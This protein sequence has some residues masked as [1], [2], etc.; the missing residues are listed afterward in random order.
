M[1]WGNDR[2]KPWDGFINNGVMS[3]NQ[4]GGITAHTVNNYAPTDRHIDES[5]KTDLRQQVSKTTPIRVSVAMGDAE[6]HAFGLEIQAFLL[7]DGFNVDV[8][9][10]AQCVWMSPVKGQ[11]LQQEEDGSIQVI[12]GSR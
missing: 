2:N 9:A 3:V 7:A 1:K 12:I 5:L 4:S 6:A 11:A 10:F 8:N